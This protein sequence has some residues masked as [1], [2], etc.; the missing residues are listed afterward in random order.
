MDA[1]H[2]GVVRLKNQVQATND[3]VLAQND[4]LDHISVQVSDTD[5][6]VQQQTQV[7]RKVTSAH[8]KV[9]CVDFPIC[10]N[11]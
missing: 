10:A 3:E 1:I 8:R 5:A 7:A 11:F 6:A 9:G 4:L 2:N